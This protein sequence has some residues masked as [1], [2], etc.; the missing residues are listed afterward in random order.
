MCSTQICLQQ[1]SL[2]AAEEKKQNNKHTKAESMETTNH[3]DTYWYI[4]GSEVMMKRPLR[5]YRGKRRQ[6]AGRTVFVVVA[7]SH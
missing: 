1:L 3:A 2:G 4:V 7:A 6:S 5:P